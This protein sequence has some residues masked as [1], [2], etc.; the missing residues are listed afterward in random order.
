MD[1]DVGDKGLLGR[2]QREVDRPVLVEL[3]M[4]VG[5]ELVLQVVLEGPLVV[6]GG[7]VG[8][9]GRED[10]RGGGVRQG[11]GGVGGVGQKQDAVGQRGGRRLG[12]DA[13]AV[14]AEAPEGD[15]DGEGEMI[16][17]RLGIVDR[18]VGRQRRAFG[19]IDG[20]PA[21]CLCADT[22]ADGPGFANSRLNSSR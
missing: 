13:L 18:L 17:R 1:R 3:A 16:G 4:D 6:D 15:A 21:I 14:G 9:P 12:E 8:G 20:E 2:R 10:R 22:Q 5:E 7:A 11:V 19:A